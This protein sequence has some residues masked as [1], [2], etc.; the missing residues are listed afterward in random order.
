MTTPFDQMPS[1]VGTT[2][3]TPTR[4]ASVIYDSDRVPVL[5]SD[6]E[7]DRVCFFIGPIGEPDSIH[8]K[9]SDLVLESLI[10][11]AMEEFGME[12]R[13]ADEIQNPGLINKQV[14]EYLLKARLAIA[15]LSYHNPNVFYEM[16]VRHARNLPVVQ[17]IRKADPIPFDVNQ[18]RTVQ[19][20]MT[21]LYSFVPRI[22]TYKA[23]ISNHIRA[24]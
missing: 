12:V 10:R 21:D 13:R 1:T 16:A 22:G 11:P 7:F 24:L 23:E 2:T 6:A 3:S 9:H 17:I 14:F 18:S 8:R 19:L 20:D 4:A 5:H 15:D